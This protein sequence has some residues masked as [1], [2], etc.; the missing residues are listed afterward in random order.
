[1]EWV[2]EVSKGEA[3]GRVSSESAGVD[4][5]EFVVPGCHAQATRSWRARRRQ[6]RLLAQTAAHGNGSAG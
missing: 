3:A 1:V 5:P 2:L 6:E 4:W